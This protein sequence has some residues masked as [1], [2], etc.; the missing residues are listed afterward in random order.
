MKDRDEFSLFSFLTVLV[1][2]SGSHWLAINRGW[3]P[4][5][6]PLSYLQK[7]FI[8]QCVIVYGTRCRFLKNVVRKCTCVLNVSDNGER[9]SGNSCRDVPREQQNSLVIGVFSNRGKKNDRR[10][11]EEKSVWRGTKPY[12]KGGVEVECIGVAYEG[13][14]R[15]FRDAWW[16]VLCVQQSSIVLVD[17]SKTRSHL[18]SI[19]NTPWDPERY[20]HT[21]TYARLKWLYLMVVL[22]TIPG[23]ATDG[24]LIFATR[25]DHEH[26]INRLV[27]SPTS[28]FDLGRFFPKRFPVGRDQWSRGRVNLI[29]RIVPDRLFE[30]V[31]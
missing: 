3:E 10:G 17:L 27:C 19:F 20:S 24:K 31:N 12:R 9:V 1:S 18:E 21:Y 26:R 7:G 2:G 22:F 5:T 25:N 15:R 28:D 11:R 4:K 23:P 30:R 16:M 6:P 13:G 29:I 8:S 14:F